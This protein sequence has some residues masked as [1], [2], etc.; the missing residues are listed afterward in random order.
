MQYQKRNGRDKQ[1]DSNNQSGTEKRTYATPKKKQN[2]LVLAA[3]AGGA[4]LVLIL[5]I[6]AASSSH[7]GPDSTGKEPDVNT[8]EEDA[9]IKE[10]YDSGG[11]DER[12]ADRLV[13][14]DDQRAAYEYYRRAYDKFDRALVIA[15]RLNE[16][17]PGTKYAL[18]EQQIEAQL[19]DIKSKQGFPVSR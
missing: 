7:G 18:L 9:K 3:L 4:F 17:F 10:L 15:K 6:V 5:I 8:E 13:K 16:L 1:K 19:A 2:P 12:D 11:A 14:E